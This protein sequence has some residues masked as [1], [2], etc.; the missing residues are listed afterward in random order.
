MTDEDEPLIATPAHEALWI[1]A[2]GGLP[3]DDDEEY[4]RAIDDIR[5]I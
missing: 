5:R 2:G 3:P 4:Y 1:L